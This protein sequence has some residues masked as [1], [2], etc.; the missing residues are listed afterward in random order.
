[1]LV[2]LQVKM[3]QLSEKAL[4]HDD[5][6]WLIEQFSTCNATYHVG[7]DRYEMLTQF[8]CFEESKTC[9]LLLKVTSP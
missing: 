1:M 6:I 7:Y 8:D 4:V 9:A 3:G 5:R 2:P